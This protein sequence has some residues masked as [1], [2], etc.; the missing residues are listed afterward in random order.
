MIASKDQIQHYIGS[1]VNAKMISRIFHYA[2]SVVW[3][4][5][6][7]CKFLHTD[8]IIQALRALVVRILLCEFHCSDFIMLSIVC[9][10]MR[11]SLC[12]LL[13]RFYRENLSSRINF[14][15][16]SCAQSC[17]LLYAVLFALSCALSY[18]IYYVG[19][20]RTSSIVLVR[21]SSYRFPH[22]DS[23]MRILLGGLYLVNYR[24]L[25]YGHSLVSY[26]TVAVALNGSHNLL[27]M[28][29]SL[30]R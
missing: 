9:S 8:F 18:A 30:N 6:Y 10:I 25:Y 1:I 20:Y 22:A 24:L 23:I 2:G 27:N 3:L 21:I 12:G 5:S 28:H 16:S 13:S 14:V 11:I 19:F 29:L 15:D 7:S 4:L 17:D 26:G